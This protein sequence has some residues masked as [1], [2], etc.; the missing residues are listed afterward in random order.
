MGEHADDGPARVKR[1]EKRRRIK[2]NIY[3]NY[4]FLDQVCIDGWPS[5]LAWVNINTRTHEADGAPIAQLT[6][7]TDW[8]R[9]GSLP[10]HSFIYQTRSG[11][12]R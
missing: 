5:Y 9:N 10:S 4:L 11:A 8:A 12:L 2:K 6:D 3:E 1:Y 7:R